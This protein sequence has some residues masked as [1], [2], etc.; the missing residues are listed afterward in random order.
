MIL[1]GVGREPL[2]TLVDV[3]EAICFCAGD[4]EVGLHFMIVPFGIGVEKPACRPYV[5]LFV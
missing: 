1:D 4:W 5:N 2:P 3:L